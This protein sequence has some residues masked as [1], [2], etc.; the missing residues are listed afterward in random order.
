MSQ[1][2]F[3]RIAHG[4]GDVCLRCSGTESS[5]LRSFGHPMGW[6]WESKDNLIPGLGIGTML[7]ECSNLEPMKRGASVSFPVTGTLSKENV[8]LCDVGP[9]P[10]QIL[11]RAPDFF[12]GLID[13][14]MAIWSFMIGLPPT[15]RGW[16]RG[17][18]SSPLSDGPADRFAGS[19]PLR[20]FGSRSAA[21]A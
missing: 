11:T 8:W 5:R 12:D 3:D 1:M 15:P 9:V 18:V 16:R 6:R 7:Q 17:G 20:S 4:E 21:R 14:S 13:G 10:T 2:Q 19:A